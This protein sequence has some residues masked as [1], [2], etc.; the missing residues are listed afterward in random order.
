[1]NDVFTTR[2]PI[3]I[4]SKGRWD[5]RYTPKALERMGIPYYITVEPQEYEKYAA[6]ID[7]KKILTLPFSNHGK[8]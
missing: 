3:Y 2:F 8:G 5:S 7:P 6:V 1:M 4:I